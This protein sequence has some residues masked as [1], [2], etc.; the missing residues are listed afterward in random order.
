MKKS[1]KRDIV[2]D[3]S[4]PLQSVIKIHVVSLQW[5]LGLLHFHQTQDT[6]LLAAMLG[7]LV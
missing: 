2:E 4:G 3:E 6:L 5:I 7:K 1:E